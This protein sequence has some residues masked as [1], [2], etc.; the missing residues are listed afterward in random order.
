MLDQRCNPVRSRTGATFTTCVARARHEMTKSD[1]EARRSL[2]R[3]HVESALEHILDHAVVLIDEDGR[4]AGWNRGAERMLG[5]SERE[6]LREPHELFF[7]P[8]DREAG[9]PRHELDT[10]VRLGE[11]VDDRWHLRK[12]GSRFFGSGTVVAIRDE[13]GGLLGF[14]KIFRDRTEQQRAVG[15]L[16]ESER[17]YRLL[18]NSVKDYAIF[19]L[20]AD[21]IVNYWTAAAE[22]IKGYTSDE[23]IGCP[24]A[25][26]FTPEDR[27]QGAPER[28]LEAARERGSVEGSGWRVRKDGSRFW[29]EEIA[30][31]VYDAS[32]QFVGYSKI[33]RDITERRAAELERERLL[34]E[35]TEANRLKEDFLS[36]MSHELRTPL[37]AILG[38]LQ[39]LRLRNEVPEH[40]SEALSVLERNART[41]GRLIEDLLD[42]SR[43]V[44]GHA[45]V[46]LKALAARGETVN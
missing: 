6:A 13:A 24:F 33:T 23:I 8:E 45:A 20:D 35:A 17:R 34:R 44:T 27:A 15:R 2:L 46:M 41:Q 4:I 14:V 11:A 29:G 31:A 12:D 1:F 10:A 32:G 18:V 37:N 19:M 16:A 28:E 36:T 43:I 39:L 22:R 42:A 7:T 5:H 40:L 26:F 9:V 25:T 38:W 3:D 30:T 21:G